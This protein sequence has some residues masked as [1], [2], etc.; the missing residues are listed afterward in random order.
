MTLRRFKV[1]EVRSK[2][3]AECLPAQ[4]EL[5]GHVPVQIFGADINSTLDP[6]A[7]QAVADPDRLQQ[8]V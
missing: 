3:I 5:Y 1:V 2:A 4:S 7:G 6:A 8:I